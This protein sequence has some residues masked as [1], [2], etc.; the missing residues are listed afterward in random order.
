M[1]NARGIA[2][3]IIDWLVV[4]QQITINEKRHSLKN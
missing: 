3:I 4:R 1:I 2:V